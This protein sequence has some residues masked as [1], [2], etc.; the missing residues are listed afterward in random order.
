ME[1][2]I[3]SAIL[4]ALIS[5]L[6]LFAVHRLNRAHASIENE[7]NR[8]HADTVAALNHGFSKKAHAANHLY[9]RKADYL[10]KAYDIVG[11]LYFWAEKVVVPATAYDF[12]TDKEKAEK[13]IKAFEDFRFLALKKSP[14]IEEDSKIWDAQ[15][16]MM[17]SVNHIHNLVNSGNFQADSEEWKDAV[18]VFQERLQPLAS[19]LKEEVRALMAYQS[20]TSAGK[21]RD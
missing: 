13:M 6:V 1:V 14:F 11:E 19:A 3:S 21:G 4:A 7:L 16:E 5:G 18:K 9:T 12:G 15:V 8:S 10:E 20:L 2:V 17:G